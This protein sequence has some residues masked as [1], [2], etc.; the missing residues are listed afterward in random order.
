MSKD[1]GG[2]FTDRDKYRNPILKGLYADPDI[3]QFGDRYYI[4]PTTDGFSGWSGTQFH[5]FS[6][7]DLKDWKDEGVILDVATED[8]TWSIGSAWAP[9][10]AEK[11][12]NYYYYFCAKNKEGSSCIGAAVSKSPVGPFAAMPEPL[13]TME[14]M[15]QEKVK[16]G[17]TIDPSVFIDED[18]TP[19]LLFGN[20]EPAIVQLNEDML[21][22]QPGTVKQLVGAYDFREAIIVI[23]RG[24]KYHFTWSCDDTGSEN[25]HV[26]Y[27]ISGNIYGPIEFQYTILQKNQ[28]KDILGTG[29][30]SILKVNGSE[31]YFIVYHRFGTPLAKYP[32]GKGFYREV[33]LDRVE[34]NAD[35]LMEPIRVTN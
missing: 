27:G 31:E 12:G 13:L 23:K 15:E 4:Y 9:A 7:K 33:C 29:H 5:V 14:I 21:S 28:G 11:G 20:G 18:G 10:I 19:Y 34:F 8:V 17:Q 25:Y 35:G 24:D 6:S 16:M 32:E 26:N 3:A 1:S 30:H 2:Y 22:I